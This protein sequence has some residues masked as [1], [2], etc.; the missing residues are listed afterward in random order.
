MNKS[1]K[2]L[3]LTVF[4]GPVLVGWAVSSWFGHRIWM[5]PELQSVMEAAGSVAAIVMAIFL[6]QDRR[7]D[8]AVEFHLLGVG[9]ISMGALDLVH[10][11]AV[12]G[13]GFVLSRVLA[14]LA[15]AGWFA[16]IW[17]APR[18]KK[19][20]PLFRRT[21]P[22]MMVA[23]SLVLGLLMLTQRELFP[24][25][26]N[27]GQF[28][29]AAIEI[30]LVAGV[31][32]IISA[33]RLFLNWRRDGEPDM[34][35]FAA[36]AVLFGVAGLTFPYS[37]YWCSSWWLGHVWRLLA[38]FLA[39]WWVI[40]DHQRTVTYLGDVL[41]EREQAR[42]SLQQAYENVEGLVV[43]RTAELHAANEQLQREIVEREETEKSLRE[44]EAFLQ[45]IYRGVDRGVY[46]VDV[47]AEGDF[48]YVDQNLAVEWLTGLRVADIKGNTPDELV[49][50]ISPETAAAWRR[51]LERCVEAGETIRFEEMANFQGSEK[52]WLSGLTPL[53][54]EIGNIYRIIGTSL[55]I[56][57][58][59]RAEDALRESE[60]MFRLIFEQSPLGVM[61]FDHDGVITNCN[62]KLAEILG[63]PR[64]RL[65]G[66]NMVKGMKDEPARWA[67]ED[68]LQKGTGHF[69]GDYV[70]INSKKN[71]SIKAWHKSIIS[72]D[73]R[74]LGAIGIFEDITD[75]R[76]AE[77]ALRK[78][79]ALLNETQRITKVGGW[80]YDVVTKKLFWTEEVYR[81]Y[82][83]SPLDF[84][85]NNIQKAVEFYKDEDKEKIAEAFQRAVEQ[86]EPYDLELQFT[87]AQGKELWVRTTAKVFRRDGQ[88]VRVSG[89]FMD[90]TERKRMEEELTKSNMLLESVFSSLHEAVLVFTPHSRRIVMA[91]AAIETM[92]GY[93]VD[94]VIGRNPEFLHVSKEMFQGFT[95]EMSPAL[96][97]R[98]IF[99]KEFKA[100]RKDGT[101]FDTEHV[102]TEI[103]DHS[104]KR[105]LVVG[106]CRDNSE[107]KRMER[108]LILARNL[109]E[110]AN[111]A[112]SEFLANM[113][114][115]IRTPVSGVMGMADMLLTTGLNS[116]QKECVEMIKDAGGSLLSILN[117]VL[118]F[119]KIE[120]G[121][122]TLVREAFDLYDLLNNI[123]S[124][125]MLQTQCRNLGLCYDLDP[126][127]P[128]SLIGDAG[129]LRQILTNLVGNSVKFTERG[130][131]R[132]K[133]STHAP[134]SG[135]EPGKKTVV[136]LLFTIC[137]S[138]IGIQ[139][140]KQPELFKSFTQAD[141]SI[142]KKYGGTGLGLAISKKLVEMMG[143]HI[144]F[145]SCPGQGSQ[146]YFTVEFE[147]ATS[148]LQPDEQPPSP[149]GKP[150]P[151]VPSWRILLAEDNLIT[152]KFLL[153]FLAE[154]GQRVTAVN[155][156]FEA[157]TAFEQEHFDVILM[158]V[159]MPE[160]DGL[161]AVRKIRASTSGI[162]D[163]NIPVIALTAYA[164]K[165]DRE[166]FLEAGMNEYVSKPIEIDQ[167]FEIIARVTQRRATLQEVRP[168]DVDQAELVDMA[169]LRHKHQGQEDLFEETISLCLQIIPGKLATLRQALSSN[170]AGLV[171]KT[172]HSLAGITE[173][174]RAGRAVA[175]ARRLEEAALGMDLD[176][177][178]SVFE[179]LDSELHR[180]MEYLA[181]EFNIGNIS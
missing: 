68:A 75:R 79:E 94:E 34:F 49:P 173:E 160:M 42:E 101:I 102:V 63:A 11:V 66:F 155:N 8:R 72:G 92:F 22:S 159:Q 45:S 83:V 3:L 175:Y 125:F 19:H 44:R 80:E 154:T 108:E 171:Q 106:T 176:Q 153:H 81:I 85:L 150:G 60:E 144:W 121:K 76:R 152:Q 149:E 7:P 179:L 20:E 114:H 107:R 51:G 139:E 46:A 84:D 95:Q 77:E 47:T 82:G 57:D 86:G 104:G 65:I 90:I 35:L 178:R 31:L 109:A 56:T 145:E 74:F 118:D 27:N 98:G 133:V 168:D 177:A 16:L 91:N 28:T 78:S 105:M 181:K 64:E 143:G 140:D 119:S 112:K 9:F 40:S 58:R 88:V 15:G 132:V 111:R 71:I 30:N 120:A 167:L 135:S 14:S 115:E 69:E 172:A 33:C 147:E 162:N 54:N 110:N 23:G 99:R 13:R 136:S 169:K 137:D 123:M 130:E 52:W 2:A 93:K 89:N 37:R 1:Q 165:G 142:S 43:A 12:P 116:M 5:N 166:K 87:T 32:F 127:V 113:S 39:L 141:G 151:A 38:F 128:R 70:T 62:E 50:M 180:L 124:V 126:D 41:V 24:L 164:M 122:V 21:I 48:R 25:M 6:L 61:Q 18:L 26:L 117:D 131:I 59:R 67:V 156:G 73:G 158:D 10:A 138:G 163:P 148:A 17:A 170:D 4:I 36:L 53:R 100:R 161:E 134:G 29:T 146:F 103:K 174:I 129:R 96:D 157:L 97:T 55:D